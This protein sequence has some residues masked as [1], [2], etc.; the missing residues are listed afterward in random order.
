M[1]QANDEI[2]PVFKPNLVK[3]SSV[4]KFLHQIDDSRIY[5]N[6]GPLE[7]RLITGFSELFAIPTNRCLLS[8]N[9]TIALTQILLYLKHHTKQGLNKK[10][11]ICPDWTFAAS[12]LAII[13]AGLHP[14]FLDVNRTSMELTVDIVKNYIDLNV[15][16]KENTL[17]VLIVSPFGK[18][19]DFKSWEDFHKNTGIELIVDGA[20]SFDTFSHKQNTE[21]LTFP[22]YTAISLHATKIFGI[23]EGALVITPG[24]SSTNT[25]RSIGN[26][27]FDSR[28]ISE[29]VSMNAKLSE[30]SAAVGLATLDNWESTRETWRRKIVSFQQMMSS[31][32]NF[33]TIYTATST[34]F[35]CTTGN[36]LSLDPDFEPSKFQQY[37]QKNN[38]SSR[39][40]WPMPLSR[41]PVFKEFNNEP[42]LNADFLCNN[43][44]GVPF[45]IDISEHDLEKVFSVINNYA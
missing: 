41:M 25:I 7:K 9:C 18:D 29:Y 37:L 12:G 28:R 20:A 1:I 10:Y 15:N 8:S 6:H 33:K 34:E 26:F 22:G 23:G 19:L 39:Q 36:L 44:I 45:Y 3:S 40:W 27:G 14:I 30:F 32:K 11:V 13:Q 38:I 35:L 21:L 4:V 2:I 17:A 16:V 5:S 43:L 42:N 24:E 31:L